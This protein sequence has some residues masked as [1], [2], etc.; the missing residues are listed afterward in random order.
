MQRALK[1]KSREIQTLKRDRSVK[2]QKLRHQNSLL[3]NS[4]SSK[5]I[6]HRQQSRVPA[7]QKNPQERIPNRVA[8][9]RRINAN[10]S[11]VSSR[12]FKIKNVAE[13]CFAGCLFLILLGK[14]YVRVSIIDASYQIENVRNEL[15]VEDAKLRELRVKK[16]MVMSPK[17]LSAL[18]YNKLEMNPILPQQIRRINL[19]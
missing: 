6:I 2:S 13:I 7:I 12:N 3:G 5:I 17:E 19:E 11:Q 10:I 8:Q 14:L 9:R 16:A 4:P 1:A 15:L 18:A